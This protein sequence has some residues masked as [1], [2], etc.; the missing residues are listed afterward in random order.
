MCM[1]NDKTEL[2]ETKPIPKAVAE[3][4][5]PTILSTLVMML[6]NLADTYFVGMLNDPIQNAAVTLA[7]PV[8]LAFNAINNLFG[9]GSSSVMSRALGR[10]DHETVR[11]ASCFSFYCALL[12]AAL[13]SLGYIIFRTPVLN[14]LGADSQTADAT[15]RYMLWTVACGACPA[16]MNVVMS[17]MIRSEGFAMHA[18]IG[19]MSGCMLNILFDPFFILP[20]FL[21]MGAAGA[22]LAT[23]AAN[24]IACIYFFVLLKVRKNSTYISLNPK[25]IRTPKAVVL[26]IFGIGIPASIQ[27]LLNVTGMTILNNFT[28]AYGSDAVAAMGIAHKVNMIP[29]YLSMGLSQGVMPLISYN[30]TGGD[31]KRL[32]DS[33]SYVSKLM[34]FVAFTLAVIVFIES[35]FIMRMFIKNTAVVFYG[36][37]FLKLMSIGIPFIAVDFFAV[38]IYQALGKGKYSLIFAILRK[39]VLEIP[40]IIVLNYIYPLYGMAFS[41]TAAEIVL[42]VAAVMVLRKIIK[43]LNI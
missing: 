24:C 15:S 18:G 16:I 41:Q 6:Y 27:N 11:S 42:S 37:T 33:I 14:L 13:I 22:G 30:Y 21:N 5:I 7:A 38:A 28:S 10:K 35:G 43:E 23:F 26:D 39:I 25:F 20:Q 2:F 1:K 29:L 32:K 19:M 36:G 8:M 4:S 9:V 12:C 34:L 40:F 3:L 17:Y 31:H